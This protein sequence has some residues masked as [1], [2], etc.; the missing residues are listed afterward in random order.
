MIDARRPI[1]MGRYW[2]GCMG[3]WASQ[4]DEA[5]VGI[6]GECGLHALVEDVAHV[7]TEL[8]VDRA[9]RRFVDALVE[10]GSL[11]LL[12]GLIGVKQDVELFDHVLEDSFYL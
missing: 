4:V 3:V 5:G 9:G 1:G 10:P 6:D 7:S 8:I 2:Y 12:C 11:L